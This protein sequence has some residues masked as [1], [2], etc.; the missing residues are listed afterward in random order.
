MLLIAIKPL[1]IW[2]NEE[3][4]SDAEGSLVDRVIV[5]G[6]LCLGLFLLAKRKLDWPRVVKANV[7][8]IL[9]IGYALV[10]ALWS[11]VT[12]I[13]FKRWTREELLA[14]VMVFVVLT[15]RDPRQAAQS[16]LR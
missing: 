12:F 1:N 10:S 13:S 6:I 4:T 5:S 3:Q 15:E 14:V 9:L 16:V 2:L 8:L 11:D 7:W